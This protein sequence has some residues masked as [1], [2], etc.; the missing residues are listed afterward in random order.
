MRDRLKGAA[1]LATAWKCYEQGVGLESGARKI[2]PGLKRSD[3]APWIEFIKRAELAS[4]S[5][6]ENVVRGDEPQ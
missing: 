5:A 2:L 4:A 1:M 6:F 3:I